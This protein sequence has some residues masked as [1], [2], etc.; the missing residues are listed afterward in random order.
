V[1]LLW[2]LLN[3]VTIVLIGWYFARR[4]IMIKL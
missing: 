2:A 4:K 3:V 1:W